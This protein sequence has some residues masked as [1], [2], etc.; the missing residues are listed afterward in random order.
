MAPIAHHTV[1]LH[2]AAVNDPPVVTGPVSVQADPPNP[3]IYIYDIA[4][5]DDALADGVLAVTVASE[6]VANVSLLST[7]DL[8]YV[9][10]GTSLYFE[11]TL[12]AIDAAF[13]SGLTY[14]ALPEPGGIDITV[15]DL[16]NFGENAPPAL[17][18][19]H[20][21]TVFPE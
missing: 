10:N 19:M 8:F 4:V 16:G 21:I 14:T 9:N 18:G 20:H 11:G 15:D 17:T 1:S 3:V 5:A 13:A 6:G 7:D 12:E 2:V